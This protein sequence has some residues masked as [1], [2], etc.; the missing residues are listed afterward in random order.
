MLRFDL[1]VC[2]R[3]EDAAQD[4]NFRAELERARREVADVYGIPGMKWGYVVVDP[5]ARWMYD[6]GGPTS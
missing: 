4:A 3:C 2:W 6:I 1:L 5:E